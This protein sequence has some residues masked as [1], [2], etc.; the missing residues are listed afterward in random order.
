MVSEILNYRADKI[1]PDLPWQVRTSNGKIYHHYNFNAS[2]G[3]IEAERARL[4]TF[5]VRTIVVKVL[6]RNLRG[7]NNLHG[8]KYEP[9]K[10]I[11]TDVKVPNDI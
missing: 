6:S 8:K 10:W 4:K 2:L 9:S 5:G 1:L 11:F 7:K 3:D